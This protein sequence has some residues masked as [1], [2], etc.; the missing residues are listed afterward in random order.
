MRMRSL[1]CVSLAAG[2]SRSAWT[3]PVPPPGRA[4]VAVTWSSIPGRYAGRE[5]LPPRA[6][7]T[8][9]VWPVTKAIASS[10]CDAI[11]NIVPP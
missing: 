1:P 5:T 11:H 6:K 4:S 3:T 2:L 10:P 9:D 8:F 7:S